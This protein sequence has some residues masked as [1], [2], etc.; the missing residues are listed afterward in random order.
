MPPRLERIDHIH[1]FVADRDASERWY[2]DVLGFSRVPELAFWASDGGPLTLADASG[3]VHLAL[4]E[5]PPQLCR[6]TIALAA[7]AT[8][9]MAWQT[10]LGTVLGQP[11]QAV[12]HQVSWS[13]YFA[14]P[15]GNPYEITSYA[16]D[17]L[18][19]GGVAWMRSKPSPPES[20]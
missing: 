10:H 9:F 8:E 1:V 7:T 4:F 13:L 11:V 6:S 19:A 16:H 12:D 20:A 14:D 17:A 15:D 3:S 5:R 2:F 18:A